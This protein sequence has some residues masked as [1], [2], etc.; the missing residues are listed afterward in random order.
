MSIKK[1]TV[2]RA[3]VSALL[4][5]GVATGGV[6]LTLKV[7]DFQRS[8]YFD[9]RKSQAAAAAASMDF[10]E[11]ESLKGSSERRG[12]ARVRGAPVSTHSHT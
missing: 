5:A 9:L 1:A 7:A 6:L 4:L 8:Q 11:I 12:H 2:I 10:E 3:I